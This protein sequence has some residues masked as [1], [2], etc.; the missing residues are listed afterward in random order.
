MTNKEKLELYGETC[1]CDTPC[2]QCE[3]NEKCSK[4]I[5]EEH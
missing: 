3:M 2:E 5:E 1:S 4:A